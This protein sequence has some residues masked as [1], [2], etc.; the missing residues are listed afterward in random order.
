M[1]LTDGSSSDVIARRI[2]FVTA[3]ISTVSPAR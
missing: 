2:G 1:H 3:S